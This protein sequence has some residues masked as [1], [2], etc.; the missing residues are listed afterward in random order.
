VDHDKKHR[1]G[2]NGKKKKIFDAEIVFDNRVESLKSKRKN[3]PGR[4]RNSRESDRKTK[5]APEKQTGMCT[6]DSD[7]TRGKREK[8]RDQDDE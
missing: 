7:N 2:K 6:G 5:Y 4:V 3:R 8:R 1:A